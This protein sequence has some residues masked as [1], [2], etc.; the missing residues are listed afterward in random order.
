MCCCGPQGPPQVNDPLCPWQSWADVPALPPGWALPLRWGIEFF[1]AFP[2][3]SLAGRLAGVHFLPPIPRLSAPMSSGGPAPCDHMVLTK[4]CAWIQ[5]RAIALVHFEAPRASFSLAAGRRDS[6]ATSSIDAA[7]SLPPDDRAR[8]AFDDFLC[9]FICR[10]A[11]D[12]WRSGGHWTI[13]S[14]AKSRIWRTPSMQSLYY[15]CM[16]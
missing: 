1:A 14:I 16:A 11:R 8:C 12:V 5:S 2:D 6:R 10:V 15:D 3:F 13:S 4:L 9:D 7:G